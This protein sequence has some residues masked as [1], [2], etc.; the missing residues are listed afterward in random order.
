MRRR[1]DLLREAITLTSSDYGSI[2]RRQG[3]HVHTV[4]SALSTILYLARLRNSPAREH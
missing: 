2:D 1:A 4:N 3:M